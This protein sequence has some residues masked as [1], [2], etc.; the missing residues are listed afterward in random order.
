MDFSRLRASTIPGLLVERA[1]AR[2]ARVAFRAKELGV[3]R[4]TTWAALAAR[5]TAVAQGLAARFGVGRGSTVAILGDPCPEWTIADLAAQALGAV[6]YGIYPTSAPGEVRYLLEHGGARV[7]VVEDQ[8]HLDKTLAVLDDCPGVRGVIVVDTR[9]LFMY[10]SARVHRFADVEAA[11]RALASVDALARLAAAVRPDDAATIVYTSGTTG[12]PKGALYRHGPHL[13]A[14]ANI[15]AHYPILTKGEHRVVAMLPLCHTMGRNTV[16]TMPLLADVVPHYPESLDTVAESLY[17]VA[18]T[19]VF[20]VPRYLQKFAAHLLVGMDASSPLKRAAYRAALALGTRAVLPGRP[21][22]EGVSRG[23]MALPGRPERGGV[24]GAI[25]GPPMRTIARALVFRWLLEKVGFARVRLLISSGA[26]LSP[27]V[28]TL[29]QVWGVNLCEAYGQTETGGAVVS[30]QRGPYPRPG[31]VGTPAPNVEVALGDDGELRVRGPDL[32]AGYWRDPEATSAAYRDGW[33]LTGDVAERTAGGALRLIDRRKDLVITAGG[34]N[35][36]PSQIETG[37]RA[38]PY[39]SDAVVFGEGRKYLAAL[40]EMD[41]ETVAE[42]ARGRGLTHTGYAS[43]A[44]HPEVTRLLDG[45]I[46]RANASL[47]RVE[48]VKAFRVLPRELDP[49]REGE[50]VTPTR[51]VKRR[52]MLERYR[53]LVESMFASDEERR[54]T[55]EVAA[56]TRTYK[57][58]S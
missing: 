38:S 16:I 18:P 30:G 34:K 41:Y 33:L 29:W 55:A 35:V 37:L 15:L 1:R 20:T 17:E 53:D 5:V 48:Q 45:E 40:I 24:W 32:F 10:R 52:L 2:P 51:K 6:T 54:I 49:E 23:A 28:A 9:A 7:V 39:V 42:W 44:G 31:D 57:K 21:E 43:L 46:A 13:A 36:S 25:S 11:G 12:P 26:P 22:G 27:A 3:Y 47:G 19:F 50:P 58:E 4:E 8:E 56:L 14:C